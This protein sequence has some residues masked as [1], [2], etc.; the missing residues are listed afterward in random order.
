MK[1]KRD[2]D[3]PC[4]LSISNNNDVMIVS[5]DLSAVQLYTSEGDLKS[6][7]KV[8]EG[9]EARRVAFHHGMCKI[10]VLTYVQKQKSCF[11]LTYSETGDREN[12]VFF[13][14]GNPFGN[15]VK[16]K[17]HPR[18]PVAVLLANTITFI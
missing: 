4:S 6:T 12:S 8:P 14:K 3:C 9:H 1:F 17:S 16:I 10:I 15:Y 13:G 5:D 7:I 11:M 2:E 18:E